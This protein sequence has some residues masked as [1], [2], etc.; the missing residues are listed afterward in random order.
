M[1]IEDQFDVAAQDRRAEAARKELV[2][3]LRYVYDRDSVI[4]AAEQVPEVPGKVEQEPELPQDPAAAPP[5]PNA[6][7]PPAP[8]WQ[9]LREALLQTEP[10]CDNPEPHGHDG[11]GG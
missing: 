7:A 3:A 11:N 10:C 1:S 8:P 2:A 9:D 5:D 6:P 4:E